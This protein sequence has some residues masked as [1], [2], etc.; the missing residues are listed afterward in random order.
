MK[1]NGKR[2]LMLGSM[3][4]TAFLVWTVLVQSMDVQAI[5]PEET[6]VGFA[7]FN[8]W[9][10][11]LTGVHMTMYAVTDWLG[12]V[13]I[14][15]CMVFGGFGLVQLIQRRSLFKVDYD[16]LLLG[17]Y[18]SL[19]IVGYLLFEML[20]INY[21]PILIEE[22]LEASYPS[23]TTLLVLCVMPTLLEQTKRRLKHGAVKN[24][25][26]GFVFCFSVFMVVG[27]LISGVHWVTDIMGA[28]WLSAG[29][30]C[31]YKAAVLLYAEKEK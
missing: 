17:G 9:F 21:R 13:P 16:I 24:I 14:F 6:E 11:K 7:T 10:H 1:R 31:I 12:L 29:L 18:Y 27:R 23:S 19:V 8:G 28:V 5:G 15:V 22:R 3:F 25:V 30:F 4:L 20:P 26:N 2:V